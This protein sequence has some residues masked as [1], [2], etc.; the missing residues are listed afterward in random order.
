M[1][2]RARANYFLPPR[3]HTDSFTFP[4]Y[5]GTAFIETK[6]VLLR[7]KRIFRY[8]VHIS[9][10]A[11]PSNRRIFYYRR[12]KITTSSLFINHYAYAHV[13]YAIEKTVMG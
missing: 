9:V 4:A 8:Y 1:L 5:T 6:R 7:N 12:Y 3:S 10:L 13:C 11:R 2:Q